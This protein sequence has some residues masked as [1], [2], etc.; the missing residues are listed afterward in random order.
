MVDKRGLQPL[1]ATAVLAD[2]VFGTTVPT[3]MRRYIYKI[4]TANQFAGP[5]QLDLGHSDD[6]GVTHT[7]LDYIEHAVQYEMWN[8]PDEL[9]EDSLPIYIIPGGSKLY[10]STDAGDI[11]CYFLYED[12]E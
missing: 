2:G 8:D 11:E 9:K 5:N 6:A 3:N 4:K 10:L 12:S 7:T 1:Q